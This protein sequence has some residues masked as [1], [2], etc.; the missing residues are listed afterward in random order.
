[1]KLDDL[2]LAIL[3][4]LPDE[5]SRL[6]KYLVDARDSKRIKKALE[7]PYLTPNIIGRRLTD[8][9]G[10]GLV[11]QATTRA[12]HGGRLWQ[13]TEK[14]KGVLDEVSSDGKKK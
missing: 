11:V 4:V 5:G 6:G 9:Q 1:M 13:R 14:A 8:L 12:A 7:D 3:D 10:L 2:D